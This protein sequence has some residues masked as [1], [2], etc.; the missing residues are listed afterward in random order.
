MLSAGEYFCHDGEVAAVSPRGSRVAV[1]EP[2]VQGADLARRGRAPFHSS[3][4]VP[5]HDFDIC[6]GFGLQ[7]SAGCAQGSGFGASRWSEALT[8]GGRGEEPSLPYE[9]APSF[10]DLL[11]HRYEVA[12]FSSISLSYGA[13]SI[14]YYFACACR[15]LV[16][17]GRSGRLGAC[18]KKSRS[19]QQDL[20]LYVIWTSV[21][22]G[23]C[24]AYVRE[25]HDA[26]CLWDDGN[27]RQH[28]SS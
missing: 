6:L 8:A 20:L 24:M 28:I 7:H 13:R 5:A 10:N 3:E 4:V 23:T 18:K 26:K 15:L 11:P 16:E 1:V 12:F 2:C 14:V 21:C 22:L 17:L 27:F 25:G 19:G 9:S